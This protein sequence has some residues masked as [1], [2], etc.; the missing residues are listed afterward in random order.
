MNHIVGPNQAQW[1]KDLSCGICH[2]EVNEKT[3]P[4]SA[5][6]IKTFKECYQFPK[7]LSYL[8]L[9]CIDVI[10]KIKEHLSDK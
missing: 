9:C 2:E 5:S 3:V 10:N 7:V 8:Q 6:S 4:K 1:I